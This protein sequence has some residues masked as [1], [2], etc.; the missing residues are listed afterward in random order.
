MRLNLRL[1]NMAFAAWLLS[2]CLAFP[3]QAQDPI[4]AAIQSGEFHKARTLIEEA[5][6]SGKPAEEAYALQFQLDMMQR[7]RQDFS[8]TQQDVLNRLAKY[9][10]NLSAQQLEVWEKRK[11][12]EMRLIDGE[13]RYFN[14]AVSNLFLLDEAARKRKA[15]V[16]GPAADKL[17]N[18]L[19][20]HLPQLIAEARETGKRHIAPQTFTIRY[21]LSVKADA[22]PAGE[23]IRCWLPYPRAHARQQDIALLSTQ[24]ARYLIAPQD[25]LQRT[26]YLEQTATAGKATTFEVSFRYT[27]FAEWAQVQPEQVKPYVKNE[28]YQ[29][30]TAERAPHVVF[31]PELQALAKQIAGK[32]QNPYLITR[33]VCTWIAENM[34]WAG[35]LEYSTMENIP[36]YCLAN[37]HADC[38][39][40]ALLMITLLRYL[41]IP[42]K[43]QSGWAL[44]PGYKGLH[45]WAEVYFEGFGWVPVDPDFGIQPGQNEEVKYFYTHGIDPYR[46]IVND[47][48]SQPLYPVKIYPRSETVDFQRGEVEWKAGNLYFDQWS[49]RLEIVEQQ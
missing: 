32:E 19:A 41:G 11:V 7:I 42:A 1:R 36:M 12:L 47:D 5:L 23:I 4:T 3:L 49:Y 16:D 29:Q 28:V 37:G 25:V 39:M 40:K 38:G 17:G 14:R 30:F 48:Y 18:F 45:D 6:Q 31:T 33:K 10:P 2:L 8:L 24:P 15:A 34:P 27:A 43:W 46:L 22:V 35:A 20:G 44:S 9:Y 26:I 13:N 21:Q